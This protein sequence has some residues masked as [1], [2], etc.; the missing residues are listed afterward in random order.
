MIRI[1]VSIPWESKR[2][3]TDGRSV[4]VDRR[5]ENKPHFDQNRPLC[6]SEPTADTL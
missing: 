3:D 2:C 6:H 1:G 5:G 4:W